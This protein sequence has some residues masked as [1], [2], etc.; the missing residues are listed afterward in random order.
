MQLLAHTAFMGKKIGTISIQISVTPAA[1]KVIDI[2]A[3]QTEIPQKRV[4]SKLY[5]WFAELP[6]PA[7][8]SILWPEETADEMDAVRVALEYL[9]KRRLELANSGPGNGSPASTDD[10]TRA[11]NLAGSKLR[12]IAETPPKSP[13]PTPAR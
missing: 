11:R 4:L 6:V 8:K 10:R 1:K 7:Q 5:E 13:Q 2:L 9:Q 12:G 3:E